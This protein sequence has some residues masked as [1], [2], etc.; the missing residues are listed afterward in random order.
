MYHRAP[1]VAERHGRAWWARSE[2][3]DGGLRGDIHWHGL[4]K[5][6][7]ELEVRMD[8]TLKTNCLACDG[9]LVEGHCGG[10]CGRLWSA[11][12]LAGVRAI[13]AVVTVVEAQR[14][15]PGTLRGRLLSQL[16][17]ERATAVGPTQARAPSPPRAPEVAPTPS[18]PPTAAPPQPI[19]PSWIR[20]I[21]PAVA[22]H[23]LALMGAFLVMAGALY[24]VSS[25]WHVM[26]GVG[27]LLVVQGALL[28]LAWG[29][30]LAL[31]L[32]RTVESD[33]ALER[34][35]A[36]SG[37][38]SAG[39]AAVSL[40]VPGLLVVEH[41]AAGLAALVVG[42]ASALW[43]QRTLLSPADRVGP[44]SALGL[45][46]AIAAMG[47]SLG[48]PWTPLVAL[49]LGLVAAATAA[50]ERPWTR[51]PAWLAMGVAATHLAISM[52]GPGSMHSPAAF[53]PLIAGVAWSLARRGGAT[54]AVVAM[55]LAV[56]ALAPAA[57]LPA[58]LAPTAALSAI[59]CLR[60]AR[61][62]RSG[63][64]V[65]GLAASLLA[66]I[67]APAPVRGLAQALAARAAEGL[68]YGAQPLPLAWYGLT[69]LPYVVGLAWWARRCESR[70]A[71]G[72][73]RVTVGW[74]GLVAGVLC[75]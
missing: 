29:G 6:T 11:A 14:A 8:T 42:L 39:V 36:I 40:G 18:P 27:R 70:G 49:A 13:D 5:L 55:A 51:T 54:T 10:A 23:A 19:V 57:T 33:P 61:G 72:H 52:H 17:R 32:V 50:G 22:D 68:G 64:V 67:T 48:D 31:R 74:L 58:L 41:P 20:R 25:T 56:G 75:A 53:G 15:L 30:R 46:A 38:A 28:G 59:A 9:P 65:P 63:F 69:C 3:L 24:L 45:A 16:T 21:G 12:A 1:G 34:L 4:R 7:P 37:T 73:A 44:L 43:M 71:H 35:A 2:G 60:A 47:P 26:G 62:R 66:Y